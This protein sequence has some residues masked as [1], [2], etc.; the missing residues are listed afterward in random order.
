MSKRRDMVVIN[1]TRDDFDAIAVAV[2]RC[3][4][5]KRTSLK[6]RDTYKRVSHKLLPL[7]EWDSEPHQPPTHGGVIIIQERRPRGRRL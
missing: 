6:Q 5:D 7:I 4:R 1:L 2:G 3:D